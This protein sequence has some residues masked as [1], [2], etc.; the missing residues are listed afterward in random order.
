[1]SLH[2]D[3]HALSFKALLHNNKDVYVI[4]MKLKF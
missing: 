3:W 1:M 2:K 4:K